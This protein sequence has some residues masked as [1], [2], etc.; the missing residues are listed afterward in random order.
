VGGRVYETTRRF[1]LRKLRGYNN[2]RSIRTKWSWFRLCI[3]SGNKLVNVEVVL[4]DV[5]AQY[6]ELD[7]HHIL[8]DSALRKSPLITCNR[9]G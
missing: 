6:F 2:V 8:G 7:I 1:F 3:C 9:D 5:V 4:V